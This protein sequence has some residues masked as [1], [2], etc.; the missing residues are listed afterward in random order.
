[1]TVSNKT[2]ERIM[3][4]DSNL[5]PYD[6][7]RIGGIG[8]VLNRIGLNQ[9]KHHI[10]YKVSLGEFAIPMEFTGKLMFDIHPR[11]AYNLADQ[12]FSRVLTLHQDF[13]R[14]DLMKEGNRPYSIT[15]RIAYALSNTHHSDL[16]LRKEYIE[17]PRIFKEFAKVMA[18]DPIRIPRIGGVDIVIKDHPVLDRTMSSRIEFSSRMSFSEDRIIGYKGKE[19]EL[20]K[21][22]TPQEIRQ[23]VVGRYEGT[24]EIA[25]HEIFVT[26]I[27]GRENGCMTLGLSFLEDHKPWGRK[28]IREAKIMIGGAFGTPWFRVKTPPIYF[29]DTGADI[30]LGNNFIQTFARYMQD[31]QRNLLIF[32]TNCGSEIQVLRREKA[33]NR[34]MPINFR[35]KRGDVD[36]KLTDP[37]M[38][39]KR[40][41]SKVLLSFRQ[42]GLIDSDSFYEES[43]EEIKNLKEAMQ[44]LKTL[45]ISE[46]SKLSLEN[47]KRLIQRNFSKNPLAWWDRNKIEA[48]LKIKEERKYEYVRYK[49]IQMNMEDK[50]DMQMIIKEHINLGLIEPGISAYSSPGFLVRNHGEIKRGKPRLVINYQ[51][52]NKILEFDGYYIPSREHLIDCIKGAK[53]FSK[54]DCKSGFYQI[55]MENESKKFTAFSTPQGQYIW[56]VLPMGLANAPQIFQRKMDNL[57]KDYFEF[58]FVYIDDILIA[59]K[60][61]K[62]HIKH[63]E[64]FS[65]ACHKEGL[66]LSEEKATIAVNKIEFLGIRIDEAGIELQEH[67]VEKICNFPDVLKDKKQLQ[68][69]LGVVNFAG[70]FI[71]DLAKYRKDFRPLLKETESAKWKWE[72]IHTQRVRELKQVCNNL[73]KLAIPQDEDELVVYTDANDYRWAAV[74][75]KKTTTGEEPCRYTGG[76][77]TE[78]QAQVWH[79]NEKEFFAVWKAFKKW[80]L[81]K[82]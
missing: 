16:F 36:V 71:K 58:M 37:K 73:P 5:S 78:Q 18:P 28:G 23:P 56:N 30:L 67:I 25:G 49:P 3:R 81:I 62:D 53:V 47:V 64:I 17:I 2:M 43:E 42:Q 29:H 4:Q 34:I 74:L 63:L 13:K 12:D 26:G 52:I 68:S 6:G 40:K 76:L 72:E 8:K 79:I 45:D 44:E 22:L 7:F 66:V 32:T 35:S 39:D 10:I 54:F 60:N 69:F 24:L 55:K 48:T 75:M 14:K 38:Q 11:I 41:F 51:G 57:F 31:N 59:S 33:F 65:D 61:M 27:A 9:R 46:E 1:M 77:F 15:Y 82:N 21:V 80:P 19:K 70:I 50:K 20:S